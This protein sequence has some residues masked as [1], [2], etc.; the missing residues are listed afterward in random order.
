MYY[1]VQM[2][3]SYLQLLENA[4]L[5]ISALLAISCVSQKRWWRKK[6]GMKPPEAKL[7]QKPTT[8][9]DMPGQVPELLTKED[10]EAI[11]TFLC[12]FNQPFYLFMISMP[13]VISLI[14]CPFALY[15]YEPL[16][17]LF[18]P[19]KHFPVIPKINDVIAC[20]LT[21]AG[22]VYAIAFGFA[23]QEAQTKQQLMTQSVCQQVSLLVQIVMLTFVV[24]DLS[25]GEKQDIFRNL[26]KEVIDWMRSLIGLVNQDTTDSLHGTI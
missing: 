11:D 26:K 15:L 8:T 10:K 1:T 9:K 4:Y 24:E 2:Y 13:A 21:P 19:K 22:L 7:P 14:L 16:V 12:F 18:W 23:F 17:E 20:F 6:F 25:I 5:L 3:L